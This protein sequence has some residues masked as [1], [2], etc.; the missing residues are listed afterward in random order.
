MIPPRLLACFREL[1]GQ[2]VLE[3][4]TRNCDPLGSQ[5]H[6]Q[7]PR[8]PTF[9]PRSTNYLR[10]VLRTALI[11]GVPSCGHVAPVVSAGPRPL[12]TLY[13]ICSCSR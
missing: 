6:A 9:V 2:C 4:I 13:D 10:G 12:Y 3:I 8:L 5:S 7:N 1:Y 11:A